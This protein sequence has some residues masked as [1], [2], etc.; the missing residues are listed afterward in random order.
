MVRAVIGWGQ[1]W[2][3]GVDGKV[4]LLWECDGPDG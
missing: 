2:E 3:T 1:V 4:G